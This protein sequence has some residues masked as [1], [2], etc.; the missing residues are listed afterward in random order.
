MADKLEAYRGKRSRDRTS[1]PWPDGPP[2]PG[3]NDLFVIQEHHASR[4]HWDFRL[5]R[6][7]VLVSWA[8]PRGLPRAPGVNRLAVHTEDHPMEYLTFEGEI[9]AGEYGGGRMTV[10]D[11][12]KYETLHWN[13]HKVEVVFHGARARGKYLFLNRHNPDDENDWMLRRLDPADDGHED[14]PEFLEPMTATPGELP[15]DDDAWAYEFAWGGART[16]LC[17]SGGRVTA[18]DGTGADVTGRYP[19]LHKLG[20]ALGSTEVLLDGEVVVI[21]EGRP[22]PAGLEERGRADGNAAKRMTKHC[23]AFF[24]AYDVLHH[25]GRSTVALPYVERR[26]LLAGLGLT[27]GWQ[28]PQYFRGNGEAVLAAA[29]Q[30]GLRGIYAKRADSAYHPGDA[31]GDWL[32]IPV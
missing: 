14:S 23:P 19:E 27:G 29:R 17:V 10:W 32:E 21:R 18:H 26:A 6:D 5:E 24:F 2:T 8:V 20:E 12:G 30:H 4:L 31:A 1:E 16:M 28:A 25:E 9:P 3:D 11:T 7:G 22:D 15:A 13:D